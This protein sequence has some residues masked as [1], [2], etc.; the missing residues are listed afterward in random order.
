MRAEAYEAG[1][2]VAPRDGPVDAGVEIC[3]VGER[4]REPEVVKG[5]R[6]SISGKAMR[7]GFLAAPP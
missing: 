1:V 7:M 5:V 4:E 3:S 6:S 2:G